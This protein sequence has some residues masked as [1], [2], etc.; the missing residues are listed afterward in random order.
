MLGPPT[1]Q[2][3][4]QPALLPQGIKT[5][6]RPSIQ[7]TGQ[8]VLPFSGIQELRGVCCRASASTPAQ[9]RSLSQSTWKVRCL[10]SEPFHSLALQYVRAELQAQAP[11]AD[12][13]ATAKPAT[14][15]TAPCPRMPSIPLHRWLQ[16]QVRVPLLCRGHASAC[17]AALGSSPHTMQGTDAAPRT[18]PASGLSAQPPPP[19]KTG[20]G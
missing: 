14:H 18:S 15:Q 12:H 20:Q 17:L 7:V 9:R 19:S 16:R 6:C 1:P 11:L 5:A 8:K 3:Q 4:Q 10:D 2:Q 13:A